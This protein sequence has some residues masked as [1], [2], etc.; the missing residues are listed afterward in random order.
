MKK[1]ASCLLVLLLLVPFAYCV[2]I[3][4]NNNT[5]VNITNE[6]MHESTG[7][8]VYES[9]NFKIQKYIPH[10]LLALIVLVV[11]GLILLKKR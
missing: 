3:N 11:V 9:P 7:R 10:L 2:N 8:V 5:K 4:G 1:L 6:T